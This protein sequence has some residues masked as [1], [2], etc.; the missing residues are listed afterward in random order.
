MENYHVTEYL[1]NKPAGGI[2]LALGADETGA[3]IDF[4]SSKAKIEG[5]ICE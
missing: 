5:L 1:L 2:H 3:H 4:V